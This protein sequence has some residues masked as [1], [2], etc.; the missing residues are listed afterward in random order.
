MFLGQGKE[1]RALLEARRN[2]S[3]QDDA[4]EPEIQRS[5]VGR[6]A[7]STSTAERRPPSCP[8]RTWSTGSGVERSNGFRLDHGRNSNSV[9]GV[10]VRIIAVT[11][12]DS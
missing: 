8:T 9:G 2:V 5:A 11:L 1:T 4:G 3:S 6:G 10:V 7:T 12:Q